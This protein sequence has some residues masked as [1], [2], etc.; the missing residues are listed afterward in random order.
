MAMIGRATDHAA[1]GMLAASQLP[2]ARPDCHS[3]LLFGLG[4]PEG[5]WCLTCVSSGSPEGDRLGGE[6]PDGDKCSMCVYVLQ[7]CLRDIKRAA[8]LCACV[9]L[10]ACF[11]CAIV[12]LCSMRE[13]IMHRCYAADLSKQVPMS[14]LFQQ[15]RLRTR[16]KTP[17]QSPKGKFRA[18]P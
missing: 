1:S 10:C 11:A 7:V 9:L 18:F 14:M 3:P 16:A 17:S 4:L 15:A 13:L 8:C 5:V 12:L 6:A 2:Q